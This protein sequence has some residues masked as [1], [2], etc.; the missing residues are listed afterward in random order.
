MVKQYSLL[1]RRYDDRDDYTYTTKHESHYRR[2]ASTTLFVR[3]VNNK[4]EFLWTP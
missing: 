4:A 3:S 1:L 2:F